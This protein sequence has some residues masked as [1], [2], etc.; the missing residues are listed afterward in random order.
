M[1][2][3]VTDLDWICTDLKSFT[4]IFPKKPDGLTHTPCVLGNLVV[5]LLPICEVLIQSVETLI[6]PRQALGQIW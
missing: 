3:F 4:E 2:L 5:V 6:Q 1:G